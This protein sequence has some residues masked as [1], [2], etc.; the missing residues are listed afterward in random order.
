MKTYRIKRKKDIK[1]LKENLIWKNQ[2]SLKF[3]KHTE[4]QSI[5]GTGKMTKKKLNMC[6][7]A[8]NRKK[9]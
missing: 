1:D 9:I 8:R 3:N 6:V 2:I 5:K 4:A 7:E